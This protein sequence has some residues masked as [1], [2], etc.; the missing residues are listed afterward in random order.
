MPPVD[1]QNIEGR[2]LLGLSPFFVGLRYL[3]RKKLSYLAIVG[4]ALSVGVII[5]VMSVFSGFYLQMT[6]AIRGYLSDL[7]VRPLEGGMYALED[8]QSWRSSLLEVDGVEGVAPFLEGAALARNPA[9]GRMFHVF[10]RG[11]HPELEE[12]VSELP[13]YMA[14]GS[15]S[16]L[17]STHPNPEGGR[18]HSCFVGNEF[19]GPGLAASPELPELVLVTVTADLERALAKYRVNGIFKTGN[20]E[21]DNQVVVLGLDTAMQLV[22][23]RGVSGLSVG[24]KDYREADKVKRRIREVVAPGA[25]LFRPPLPPGRLTD[26]AFSGNGSRLAAITEP[27]AVITWNVEQQGGPQPWDA[28]ESKPTALALSHDGS[29]LLVGRADGGAQLLDCPGGEGL[30]GIPAGDAPVTAACFDRYG[31]YLALAR[32]EGP[33]EVRDAETGELLST[34]HGASG[35]VTDMS[36]D[37][38]GERLLVTRGEGVVRLWDAAGGEML[39]ALGA[40]ARVDITTAAFSPDGKSVATGARDGNIVLWDAASGRPRGQWRPWQKPLAR[41]RF[42]WTSR[43]L[44]TAYRQDIVGWRLSETS[45]GIFL[46]GILGVERPEGHFQQVIFQG[47]GKR[48]ATL[49]EDGSL[50]VQYT[51]GRFAVRTWEEERQTLL[52]AVKMERFLQALIMSLILVLAE[53]FIFVIITTMVYEKRRDIGILNAVGF[54]RG[55][56]CQ[57][58]LTCG[59]AI[60]V[61]GAVV[62][63]TGGVLFADN[64][65]AIRNFVHHATGWDP[66]PA[67]VYYFSEIPSH[68]GLLTPLLTGGGA[69][70]CALLFSIVPALRAAR[71]D[72][73]R[74]LHHE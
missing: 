23:A 20:Y 13:R 14:R 51:G 21:Y 44:L 33:V 29:R 27:G 58:F 59:L 16:D 70:V 41:I 48:A 45:R 62:G 42:G 56:I 3:L 67:N 55:Q 68:I 39:H 1:E 43:V 26:I 57:V 49:A 35:E 34:L 17:A 31:Y 30:L 47:D 10:F 7:T 4:V 36:F 37:A 74:T 12:T 46:E 9:T 54:T 5:V 61:V 53:F 6:A 71:M 8:W 25:A 64:I 69:I 19:F 50:Q 15:L 32:K 24:L 52:K 18:L 66:F 65:N 40:P 28:S 63:V 73:I 38:D 22:K 2:P 60:G 72:P 11:I